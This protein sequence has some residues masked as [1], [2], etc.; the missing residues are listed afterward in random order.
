MGGGGKPEREKEMDKEKDRERE[1]GVC[2]IANIFCHSFLCLST[3][4][5]FPLREHPAFHPASC[6]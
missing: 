6:C 1:E 5:Q 2:G 4:L 3:L